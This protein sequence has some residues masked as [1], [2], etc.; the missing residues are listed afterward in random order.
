MSGGIESTQPA[1]QQ[2]S[3][4]PAVQAVINA[5]GGKD[6]MQA[7]HDASMR[8][9]A[10]VSSNSGISAASNTNDCV[11]IQKGDKLRAELTMIGTP[12][13]SVY[14]G[15]NAW[16]QTGEWVAPATQTVKQLMADE[17]RHGLP[18]LMD[19]FN[20]GTKVE[21][22]PKELLQGAMCDVFRITTPDGKTDLLYADG[23]KH[24][25]VRA[26]YTGMDEELGSQSEHVIDYSDYRRFENWLE[27][28]HITQITGGKRKE[29]ILVKSIEKISAND[30]QFLMP[31]ESEVPGLKERAVSI[32]FQYV[33]NHILIRA[34]INNGS[35][36]NFVVDTGASQS[37]LDRSAA[38]GLGPQSPSTFNIT[39]GAKAMPLGFT[40]LPKLTIGE[41]TL[42]NLPFLVTDLSNLPG[43]PVGLIGANILRRFLISFNFDEKKLTLADPR[44]ASIPTG[45]TAIPIIP[46]F[47]GTAMMVKARLDN[48]LTAGF[49]VDTGASFNNLPQSVAGPLATSSVLPVG[50]IFGLDGEQI[51]IGSVKL[52]SIQIGD[53]VIPQPVFTLAP[54]GISQEGGLFSNGGMGILGNSIWSQFTTTVDYRNE[55]LILEPQSGREQLNKLLS[56]IDQTNHDY[57]RLKDG[58]AAIKTYEKIAAEAKSQDAKAAE[59]LAES[60]IAGCYADKY[61]ATKDN[62]WLDLSG[63]IYEKANQLAN[64]S[65]NR[66]IEGRVMA[67]WALT[68]LNA[69]RTGNDIT[70]AQN[71]LSRAIEKA[72]ME[73]DIYA[74]F[75]NTLLQ[76]GKH[77]EA[78]KLLDR[79]LVLDPSNWQALWAKYKLYSDESHGH[80]QS[81]VAA[82]LRHYYPNYPDVLALKAR[83]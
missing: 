46:I 82:Q 51:H 74:A 49:L 75:G 29:E 30:D 25:L 33:G 80:D 65:R 61:L 41:I 68:Y 15:K 64:Q 73:P 67:Q 3:L 13:V 76:S 47:G 44:T 56:A 37:I 72:P 50:T 39:A 32:P 10:S 27:P 38:S 62:H 54:A 11:L 26:V 77:S 23:Q 40:S 63:Q 69:P 35:E 22:Q 28:Y 24:L 9:S 79:A 58:D 6:A 19:L 52:K 71:L 4:P 57:L 14:D 66:S 42:E 53:L 43:H 83:N 48:K 2:V 17:V 7:E 18:A 20:P 1:Q 8:L 59:A 55:R 45:G 34:R 12:V 81:L 5:Y 16:T 60:Q 36:E 21:M 31:A 78:E 70:S